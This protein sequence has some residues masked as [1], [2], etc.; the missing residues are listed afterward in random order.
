M[1]INQVKGIYQAKHPR[2]RS[3]RNLVL[4]LLESFKEYHFPIIPRNKNAI[5]NSLL[6]FA[7]VFKIH[8]YPNKKYEIEIKHMPTIPNNVD[9]WQVFDDDKQINRLMDM[10][11]E[12]D[13]LSIDQV[14]MFENDD[15]IEKVLESPEYLT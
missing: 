11:E 6:V 14:S 9:H 10:F 4:D 1:I 3:Y 12:F 13:N 15:S 7:S 5:A 2:L 8:A